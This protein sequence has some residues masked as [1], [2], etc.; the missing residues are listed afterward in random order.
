ADAAK[1]LKELEDA[2]KSELEKAQAALEE[3]KGKAATAERELL[4]L[5]VA[6]R[7]GLTETQARRLVGE[8][9]EE[10][11][12]DA[13]ELIASFK[14]DDGDGEANNGNGSGRPQERLRPG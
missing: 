14:A 9:E 12:K 2:G 10:L 7:K 6:L 5:R 4:K 13:D 3:H 1:K 11:E 8:S